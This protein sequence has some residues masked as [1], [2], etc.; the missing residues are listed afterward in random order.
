MFNGEDINIFA[1]NNA[2][3]YAGDDY[4]LF[5]T[6]YRLN[7]EDIDWYQ[8]QDPEKMSPS[9]AIERVRR[10]I[11]DTL[12]SIKESKEKYA[13]D[14][15]LSYAAQNDDLHGQ[16]TLDLSNYRGGEIVNLTIIYDVYTAYLDQRDEMNLNEES[17]IA[18]SSVTFSNVICSF[19]EVPGYPTRAS[20]VDNTFKKMQ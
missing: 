10:I 1:D 14:D 6:T 17:N 19:E 5:G 11:T 8:P 18:Q 13:E 9:V 7:I 12:D 15:I 4:G 16:V 3:N 20:F 2:E